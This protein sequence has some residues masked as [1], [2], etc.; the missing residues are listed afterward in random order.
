MS[1]EGKIKTNEA[2]TAIRKKKR[3]NSL[4]FVIRFG[5]NLVIRTVVSGYLFIVNI[6]QLFGR[7][8]FIVIVAVVHFLQLRSDNQRL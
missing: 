1:K 5:E 3:K 4:D 6:F 8:L 7:L 2:H